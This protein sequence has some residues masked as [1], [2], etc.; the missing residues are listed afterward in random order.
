M[1]NKDSSQQQESKRAV[2]A[3]GTEP[4]EQQFSKNIAQVQISV[5]LRKSCWHAFLIKI[6]KFLDTNQLYRRPKKWAHW[7]DEFD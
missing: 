2:I 4:E 1:S 7:Q 3:D 6:G 5:A